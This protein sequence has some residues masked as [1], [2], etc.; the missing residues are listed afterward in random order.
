MAS[1]SRT[2]SRWTGAIGLVLTLLISLA[3]T[4]PASAAPAAPSGLSPSGTSVSANPVLSWS[5]V[6]GATAYDVEVSATSDFASTLYT[7][8]TTNRRAT[9]TGQL[10]MTKIWWR[11]RTKAASGASAWATGSFTRGKLAGPAT[12]APAHGAL[13]K[14]PSQPP[15]LKWDAVPGATSY[16]VEVDRG[17]TADLTEP[18]NRP[19][20][21]SDEIVPHLVDWVD[22][23]IYT[24]Q[25]T[26][27]VLP[28]P[29]ENGLYSWRVRAEI[30]SGQSTH[31]STGRSYLVGPLLDVTGTSPSD[32]AAVEEVVLE[33]EPVPGA[34]SYDLRVST[35]NDFNAGAIIDEQVVKGTRYSR[36]RTYDVDDF[37]WQVRARNIFGKAKEWNE[38]TAKQLVQRTWEGPG[39][40]PEL[41][42]PA[43]TVYPEAP[44][45]FYY[46]WT[47]SR[48]GSRYRI[49]LGTDSSFSEKTFVSCFTTQT[50]YTPG[51]VHPGKPADKCRP[52]IGQTYYWRVKALDSMDSSTEVEGVYSD[53]QTFVYAPTPED[54]VR[55]VSPLTGDTVDIPTLR[56]EPAL[57]ANKYYVEIKSGGKVVKSTE[58]YSTSW[59]PTGPKLDPAKGPFTWTVQ[60]IDLHG[61]TSPLPIFGA[62]KTFNV[63]GSIPTTGS[64]PLKPLSPAAGAPATPRFPALRWEPVEGAAHYKVWVGTSGGIRFEALSDKFPYPAATDKTEQFLAAGTYD[65]FVTAHDAADN[66]LGE[67]GPKA[68]FS[69]VHVAETSGHRVALDG[70]G[71]EP[72]GNACTR[73][74]GQTATAANT[75]TG[76]RATPILDWDPVPGAS[77]YMVYLSKDRN[78]QNMVYGK[79]SE[80]DKIPRTTN[81]RWTPTETLDEGQAGIAYYW[82]IRPCKSATKC[83][84]DP[85][86]ATHAFEKKSNPVELVSP[87]S[88]DGSA[89]VVRS[90]A[91]TFDWVDY[92]ETNQKYERRNPLTN[93]QSGQAARSYH[94]QVSTN[95]AFTSLVDDVKVDQT[96][97]TSFKKM[98]PEGQLYWRVQAMD[99]SGNGLSWSEAV[100][101]RKTSPRPVP[102]AP[103]G[104]APT[105]QPFRWEP[106]PYAASYDLE[107]Y[108]NGDT[109]A[110]ST[111]RVVSVNSKQVAYSVT[112]P[113]P[114]G[115]QYVWRVRRVDSSNQKGQWSGWTSFQ[116]GGAMPALR[117]PAPGAWVGTNDALF[118]WQETDDASTYQFQR[119]LVGSTRTSESVKTA[120]TAWAPYRD[121]PTG[122][123]EWRVISLDAAG[124]VISGTSWRTFSVDATGPTVVS[125]APT[126]YS[127]KPG[128][129]FKVRFSEPVKNVSST[130]VRL[131]RQGAAKQLRARVTLSSD[132]RVATLNPALNMKRGTYY[133]LSVTQG[134]TDMR[135]NR[136]QAPYSK[137]I[138]TR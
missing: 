131:H 110:S 120:S 49:D 24:T 69:V 41:I 78:F 126:G 93:E 63:S 43:N 2:R 53:I 15:L 107:V 35:D 99:G 83:A 121:I 52:A 5:R 82:Y 10:P 23:T 46:Q 66:M 113:L 136:L 108:K 12:T 56:W 58:T 39:V 76:M 92:L 25:T 32:G 112:K 44:D 132:R 117:S 127:V 116:V 101:F 75:C 95:Q 109:A 133:T 85:L 40:K 102:L 8:T 37:W 106:A 3:G 28:D 71:L 134:V 119:R 50:T 103:S 115:T 97:Y 14:Q 84:P 72:R 128:A 57:D 47:P 16:S 4:P 18:E 96:T 19:A 33:W 89:P 73:T 104:T 130:T 138:R 36:P 55:Q 88:E 34:V 77:H 94:V 105:T 6:R 27:L 91:V 17:V 123:W 118:N 22:S 45:D 38:V 67:P 1:G 86:L 64:P 114:S 135:G 9:P 60:A 20:S 74:L 100:E 65:W 51:F 129:N 122:K 62:G 80:P 79:Y 137:R 70:S 81:T 30:G 61:E 7:V 21:W 42:Y 54:E 90:N 59:T 124:K 125:Q 26:A 11:V 68:T 31:P 87:V 13:L 48:L 29:Q 98:Y 111:N